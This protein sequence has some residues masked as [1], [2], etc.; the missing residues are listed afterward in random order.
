[1][2]DE[3]QMHLTSRQIEDGTR[4]QRGFI[5]G[6]TLVC[7]FLFPV[8]TSILPDATLYRAHLDLAISSKRRHQYMSYQGRPLRRLKLSHLPN[9][10]AANP[11]LL[12]LR[13]TEDVVETY[14]ETL[15][16][17]GG[18]KASLVSTEMSR[19]DA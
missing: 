12:E 3:C 13:Y 1:M 14:S 7:I 11:K 16:R 6:S 5:S 19:S 9:S 18:G 4:S 2:T 17:E 8:L 15:N 10:T